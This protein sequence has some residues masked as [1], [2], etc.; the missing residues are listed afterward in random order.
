MTLLLRSPIKVSPR[1][2]RSLSFGN[3]PDADFGAVHQ[4]L[5]LLAESKKKKT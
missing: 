2:E 1:D 4:H 5:E 3:I